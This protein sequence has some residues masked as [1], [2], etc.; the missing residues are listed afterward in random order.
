LREN[1]TFETC[2]TNPRV[3][4]ATLAKKTHERWRWDW[5]DICVCMGKKI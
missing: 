5:R 2:P 3:S 1:L 4:A